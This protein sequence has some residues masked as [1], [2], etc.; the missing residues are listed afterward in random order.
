MYLRDRKAR[1]D[2]KK[3][4]EG[5]VLRSLCSNRTY[6]GKEEVCVHVFKDWDA[7]STDV[8]AEEEFQIAK[9]V[10]IGRVI[11]EFRQKEIARLQD[12]NKKKSQVDKSDRKLRAHPGMKYDK[13][14]KKD[15]KLRAHPGMNKY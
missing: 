4:D 15:K 6:G 14:D 7:F 11:E 12:E 8:F 5:A 3:E 1:E 2:E 13:A 10:E 9:S